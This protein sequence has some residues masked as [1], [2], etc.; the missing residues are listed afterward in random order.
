MHSIKGKVTDREARERSQLEGFW[1]HSPHFT[2]PASLS[3][4]APSGVSEADSGGF[5]CG[6]SKPQFSRGNWECCLSPHP[7]PKKPQFQGH[8]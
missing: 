6:K 7:P 4:W 5:L 8:P 1:S 3:L 2:V